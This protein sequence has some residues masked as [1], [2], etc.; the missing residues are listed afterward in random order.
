MIGSFAFETK[1]DPATV[2]NMLDHSARTCT[3]KAYEKVLNGLFAIEN[4]QPQD[5][6]YGFKVFYAAMKD[7]SGLI[8]CQPRP[9][10]TTSDLLY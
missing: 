10:P 7:F 3:D 4:H 5:G 9:K 8:I 6:W 1:D 2:A